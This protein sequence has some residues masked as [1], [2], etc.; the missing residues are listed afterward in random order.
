M[1]RRINV[2]EN[3]ETAT[4][5][6][7]K[8]KCVENEETTNWY[9]EKDKSLN[10]AAA[11]WYLKKINVVENEETVTWY[12]KKDKCSSNK[13]YDVGTQKNHLNETVLLSTQ[14]NKKYG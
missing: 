12:F 3:E 6:V 7:K 4:W 8:D 5:Y 1:L 10:L 9:V 11:I 2:V 14:K 13:T